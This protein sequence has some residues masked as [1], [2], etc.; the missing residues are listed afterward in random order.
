M[1]FTTAAADEVARALLG[2]SSR[3]KNGLGDDHGNKKAQLTQGLRA[4]A[5]RVIPP[6]WIFEISKLHH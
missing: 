5:V 2:A 1:L 4:T 6:S 3:C